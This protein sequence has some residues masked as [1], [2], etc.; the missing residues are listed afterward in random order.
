MLV[1][2]KFPILSATR[3]ARAVTAVLVLGALTCALPSPTLAQTSEA[4]ITFWETVKD[5]KDAAELQAYLDAYPKGKFAPLAKLRIKKLGGETKSAQPDAE[6]GKTASKPKKATD[7]SD[8]YRA[9][10]R[11]GE[12]LEHVRSDYYK[13]VDDTRLIQAAIGGVHKV[14]PSDEAA[15][16]AGAAL[17]KLPSGSGDGNE[18]LYKRLDIFGDYIN[19]VEGQYGD[20]LDGE[21]MI[22]AAIGEML[23]SLDPHNRFYDKQALKDLRVQHSGEFAGIGAEVTIDNSVVKIITPLDGSPAESA[24]IRAGDLI[25][26]ID[27]KPI[28]GLPLPKAVALL[29][30]KAGTPVELTVVREGTSKPFDVKVVRAPLKISPVRYNAEGD[31]GYIRITLLG[32]SAAEDFR[33]AVAA[34]DKDIGA[35]IKGY[36]VDLRNCPGGLLEQG[37]TIV[38]DLLDRGEI[39]SIASRSSEGRQR[40][41]AKDGEIAKGRRIAVLINGG[42]SSGAEIVASALK[43]HKRA[44]LVGTRTFGKATVQTIIPLKDGTAVRLTTGEYIAPSGRSIQAKGIEPD[45][46]VEQVLPEDLK[47]KSASEAALKKHLPAKDG[48]EKTGSSAYVPKDKA[49]DAQLQ[50]ALRLVSGGTVEKIEKG[51]MNLQDLERLD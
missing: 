48:V 29:R 18:A 41:K 43:D 3:V 22:N 33:K 4:E 45:V 5:S 42:T 44:T 47:G 37:V 8:L 51:K 19:A 35:G 17:S 49:E 12:V 25:T 15:K 26:K 23:T 32:D 40:F 27:G 34:L 46:V 13:D 38:D 50:R 10:D 16:K 11:F 36:V 28:S 31:V 6:P 2:F 30:G 7:K 39:V 14:Y 9:L 24:G 21:K 1:M 20:R